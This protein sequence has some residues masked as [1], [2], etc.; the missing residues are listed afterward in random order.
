LSNSAFHGGIVAAIVYA[1]AEK[2]LNTTLAAQKQPDVHTL[3]IDF[4]RPCI[5]TVSTIKVTDLKIGMGASFL[6]L[7]LSQDGKLKLRALATSTNFDA[8][9][10]T[11][12]IKT[13][14]TNALSL[15]GLGPI[16]D[17]KKIDAEQP[18]S[19][20]I[21]SKTSSD[22]MP[23][24]SRMRYMYPTQGFPMRGILDYWIS[25]DKPEILDGT[26]LAVL[27]DMSPSLSD[28][29]LGNGGIFDAHAIHRMKAEAAAKNPGKPAQLRFSVKD[30]LKGKVFNI[31]LTMDL[32]FKQR[33]SGQ[34][35]WLFSRATT[36][37]L[38]G[39]RMDLDID[40]RDESLKPVLLA[41]QAI[42][43]IDAKRRF[44]GKKETKTSNL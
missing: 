39:G 34:G 42:L 38:E 30:A 3:H 12:E 32:H 44:P 22:L 5:S 7:D 41:R 19:N 18:D 20:W 25:Y 40:V 33:V 1:V 4:L 36:K 6:Q 35:R 28:T 8:P 10:P 31:T 26:H 11:A 15:D 43:V 13:D 16:P 17:F 14:S 9:G 2:H 21:P 37:A 24:V 29:V 27:G 23:F